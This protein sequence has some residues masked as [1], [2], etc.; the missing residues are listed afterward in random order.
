MQVMD[1]DVSNIEEQLRSLE[2][3]FTERDR[4]LKELMELH[5]PTSEQ[6]DE[7][8][9]LSNSLQSLDVDLRRLRLE[10]RR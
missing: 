4:R 5:L 2:Q 9:E 8:L 3:L 10:M 6:L 1:T 7:A